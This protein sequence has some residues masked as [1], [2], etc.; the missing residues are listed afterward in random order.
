MKNK[1]WT[2]EKLLSLSALLVSLL[3]LFVFIYQTN[4]IRKQQYLSVYPHLLLSNERSGSLEYKY[5]LTNQGVGPALISE[6]LVRKGDQSFPDVIDYLEE[7]NLIQDSVWFLHTNLVKGR[8][9]SAKEKLYLI[10]LASEYL[11]TEMGLPPNTLEGSKLL[12]K[13]LNAEDIEVEI[14]YES[15]YGERWRIK[16]DGKPPLKID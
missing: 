9:I 2:S 16:N 12:H 10:E 11:T 3:T 14:V 1:F 7:T 15:I 8:L 13:A 6:V 4:L 5:A